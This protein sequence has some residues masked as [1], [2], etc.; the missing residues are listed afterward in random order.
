ML[1]VI[2]LVESVPARLVGLGRAVLF[3][4]HLIRMDRAA[5]LPVSVPMTRHV[6]RSGAPA[7]VCL[8]GKAYTVMSLAQMGEWDIMKICYEKSQE[9]L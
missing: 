7:S 9:D 3:P 1:D 6:T 4:A 2:Q 8:A 5:T